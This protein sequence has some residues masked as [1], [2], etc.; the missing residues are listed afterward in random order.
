MSAW[1]DGFAVGQRGGSW[2]ECRFTGFEAQAWMR[3]YDAGRNAAAKGERIVSE[4]YVEIVKRANDDDP[5]SIVKVMGPM[6]ERK[7]DRVADGASINLNHADY[8]VRVR[9]DRP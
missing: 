4:F 2:F 8:F 6:S 9:K 1:D 3:G 5:E 7:A